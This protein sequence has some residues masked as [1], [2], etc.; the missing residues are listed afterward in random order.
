LKKLRVKGAV[1]GEDLLSKARVTAGKVLG[2]NLSGEFSGYRHLWWVQGRPGAELTLP[3]PVRRAGRYRLILGLTRSWDYGI[4]QIF[5]NG[6][7]RGKPVNLYAPKILPLKLDL[8]EF[9]LKNRPLVL[10]LR[11][12]GA[13]SRVKAKNY[14]AG[15]DYILLKPVQ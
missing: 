11:C 1:E 15:I 12:I 3:V 6:T 5:V 7:P 2:Q 4:F 9:T 13:D 8:G 10:K 14:M